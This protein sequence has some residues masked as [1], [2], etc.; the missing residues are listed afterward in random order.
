[1]QSLKIIILISAIITLN[2]PAG[3]H[4]L[5]WVTD[6]TPGGHYITG[7]GTSFDPEKPGIEIELYRMVARQLN[8]EIEFKRLSWTRCLYLLEHNR[9]DGIFPASFK[10]KRMKIGAYPMKGDQVD[11]GR[12]TRNNAYFLY[13]LKN[14]PIRWDG[15][16]FTNKN[17]ATVGV[18]EGWAIVE[19]VQKLYRD[20]R[21]ET[22]NPNI[23]NLLIHGRLDGFICLETVF[24]AY[25]GRDP[26]AYADIVKVDPSVWEKPYYLMLSHGFVAGNPEKA[27]QIWNAVRDIKKSKA[28]S[29]VVNRY[30][31]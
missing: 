21:E 29:A 1:M 11:T 15:T 6:D 22:V 28:Y 24:D 18:P 27:E 8:L 16:V 5:V 9:V 23:P 30:V 2:P 14:G 10:R 17:Q 3:A 7:G 31:D 26:A 12:K 4:S 19:V 25:L 13:Q 20:V